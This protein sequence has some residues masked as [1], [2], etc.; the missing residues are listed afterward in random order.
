MGKIRRFCK[1]DIPD[2]VRLRRQVFQLTE[3]PSDQSLADCYE[4]VLLRNPWYDD[5]L[6]SLVYENA[7]GQPCGF[8]GVIGRPM[9]FEGER[10]RCAVSTEFMVDPEE[11][12]IIG[13][14]L[15]R[16]FLEGGQDLSVSDRANDVG[17]N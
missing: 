13:V 10:V 12:G 2:I 15:L 7:R 4:R 3:R 11:R 6:S 16:R 14:Q 1:R 17:R 5:A 9:E 8:I